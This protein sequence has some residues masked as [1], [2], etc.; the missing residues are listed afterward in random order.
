MA[1][2]AQPTAG[3]STH[4][5]ADALNGPRRRWRW[6]HAAVGFAVTLGV[7]LVAFWIAAA[8]LQATRFTAQG[9]TAARWGLGVLVAAVAGRWIVYPLVRRVSDA[10]LALYLEERVPELGGAVLSAV[11]VAQ[12]QSP[13]DGRSPLLTHG[14]FT[15]ATRRLARTP[16]VGRLEEGVTRR[17]LALSALIAASAVALVALG[18]SWAGQAA[19]LLL[20]PWRDAGAAPVYAIEVTPGHATVARGSDVEVGARLVGFTS[21]VVE[22][23]LR[24]GAN[25][26]WEH[27]PMGPARD[28]TRFTARLFDVEEGAEYFVESN[29]VRSPPFRL[30]VKELPGVRRI[31]LELAYPDYTGLA[32]ERLEDVGDVAAVKGTRVTVRVR[33]TRAVRG[34]RLVLDGDSSVALR[35]VDDS[36]LAATIAVRHDGFYRVELESSDGTRVAGNV[37]YVIDAMDDR[38]PQVM[39]RKPGRDVRPTS[40]EEVL[41]ESEATD[42]YGVGRLELR[43]QVNGGEE[44]A[45]VLSAGRGRRPRQLSAGHT[46]FLEEL[47]LQPGDVVSYFVVAWDNDAVSGAKRATTDIYFLTIRPFDREYRQNQQGGGGGGGQ[48][49]DNPG[50]LV[51]RQK[52]IIAATFKTERD[53]PATETAE[54]RNDVTTIHLAQGQLREQVQQTLARVQRPAVQAADTTFRVMAGLMPKVVAEMGTAEAML[55]ARKLKDALAPEQRALQLLERVDALFREVQVSVQ[56]GG[57]GGGGGANASADDLADL[58]ELE[59]D[60]LRNQYE[61]V[62]SG[63]QQQ[64]GRDVDETLERLKR[65]AARQQQENERARQRA[66]AGA[67]GGGGGGGQRQMAEEAEQLARRLERLARER[68]SPEL[69]ETARAL[70]EAANA[71]R[72]SAAGG[73]EQGQGSGTAA[74]DRLESARRLLEES[75]G[76]ETT[77]GVEGAAERARE[78]ARQQREVQQEV[79]RLGDGESRAERERR[80]DARKEQMAQAVERLEQELDRLSRDALRDRAETARKLKDAAN[81]IREGRIDDKIRFSRDVMRGASREY[82]NSLEGQITDDLDRLRDRVAGASAAAASDSAQRTARSLAQARDLV[83]SLASIDERMR[84][85]MGGGAS[86][87]EEGA[88]RARGQQER[89]RGQQERARGQQGMGGE[90]GSAATPAPNGGG[91]GGE[92]QGAPGAGRLSPDDVRQ[93]SRELRAQ[94]EGAEVL[95]RDLARDGRSTSDLDRLIARL[96]RLESGRAFSA[97]EEFAR[98]RAAVLEGFKEF[99]FS[100][101]RQLAERER[102]GPVL[103]G[104]DDVPPGY[105]DLVSEYFRALS[106][107]GKP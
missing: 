28:S 20:T 83:R 31:D 49:G 46:L 67:T 63:T 104:G 7:V 10:R 30:A 70:Q 66:Q 25:G 94:R 96:R 12:V 91:V 97:P 90:R 42:D 4:P 106:R 35:P 80:L 79:A 51:A 15:D 60:K 98:L 34:G 43:Y 88:E 85:R 27:V 1:T 18:P 6:R 81:A 3:A 22:L 8:A 11:E 48:G 77:R 29:G 23:F 53:R 9:I 103:G 45:V 38:P 26:A 21:D 107:K 86:G 16:A 101:R 14:L 17:A 56:S 5:L 72:R 62:Q 76:R 13:D 105:R 36:T 99:E 39:V 61:Q 50:T 40:V 84:E 82:A 89:A 65:L 75:R 55:A 92:G 93:F 78:L 68:Q 73:G 41:V 95:R 19:R 32:A 64:A 33:A 2:F 58:F 100:L 87:E 44:K 54:F 69:Q 59:T 74:Q 24:R 37:D 102:Q 57:G 71:M 47:G 52:E